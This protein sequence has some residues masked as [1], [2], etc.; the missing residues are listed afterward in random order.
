[1]ATSPVI[2]AP[3]M[4]LSLLKA[5]AAAGLSTLNAALALELDSAVPSESHRASEHLAAL[6][7]EFVAAE[8][9]QRMLAAVV[10]GQ[11]EKDGEGASLMGMLATL[12]SGGVQ[13]EAVAARNHQAT[14]RTLQDKQTQAAAEL[15][16]I[17]LHTTA[18]AS[19]IKA[20]IQKLLQSQRRKHSNEHRHYT[21]VRSHHSWFHGF[22]LIL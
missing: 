12:Q 5:G 22:V 3:P 18:Q 14:M 4:V 1:M 19:A 13:G 8:T 21:A 9:R 20:D 10:K 6:R 16:E 7:A 15:A 11:E 17:Q 2:V